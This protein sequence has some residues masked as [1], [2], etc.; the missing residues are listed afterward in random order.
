MSGPPRLPPKLMLPDFRDRQ[1]ACGVERCVGVESLVAHLIEELSVVVV[2]AAPGHDCTCTAPSAPASAARPAVDTV[3]SSIAPSRT[4][5]KLK[6]L[7]LPLRN[8]CEL[9]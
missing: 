3:T 4:G 5:A 2:G 7:V 9:L 1:A 6:K 8:R